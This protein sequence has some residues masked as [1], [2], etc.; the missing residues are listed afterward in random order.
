MLEFE[1]LF[2]LA[3]YSNIIFFIYYRN[4]RSLDVFQVTLCCV[5]MYLQLKLGQMWMELNRYL[6][7][8]GITPLSIDAHLIAHMVQWHR[9]C[10][11]QIEYRQKRLA[12]TARRADE[13]SEKDEL[14]RIRDSKLAPSLEA[15]DEV[16]R[17]RRTTDR[18]YMLRM[19]DRQRRQV[20]AAL[21]FPRDADAKRCHRTFPDK[22][23]VTVK[24]GVPRIQIFL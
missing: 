12:A 11:I 6:Q 7:Q 1:R 17:I 8:I 22:T 3:N 23:N 13:V 2:Y 15:L 16:D 21:S 5:D 18:S 14:A 20:R 10:G 4:D 9:S 19:K 24:S